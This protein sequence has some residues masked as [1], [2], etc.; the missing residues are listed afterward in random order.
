MI[1]FVK[2]YRI[3]FV[4]VISVFLSSQ[5]MAE[6]TD[7]R[8]LDPDIANSYEGGCKD[9]LAEGKGV[10]KGRDTYE[11]EF[12]GGKPNGQGVYTWYNGDV[13]T[14]E[15]ANGRRNGWGVLKRPNGAYY[16]GEWLNGQR[17]GNGAYKWQSGAYYEG[18]WKDDERDGKGI[19]YGSDNSYYK[20]EWKKGLQHGTGLYKWPDGTYF[21]GEWQE[22]K[23]VRESKK[24]VTILLDHQT[25]EKL[26]K[27]RSQTGESVS[28]IIARAI[29]QLQ[30]SG[31]RDVKE[32]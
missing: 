32:N 16:E 29:D 22:G 24:T 23:Q 17:H 27:H 1:L 25:L 19:F 10:A 31:R 11:G 13:Y 9:G 8:V 3:F 18:S 6:K 30:A 12:H 28:E 2:W 4:V 21:K 15:W 20:G 5:V 26:E 7:C 14:G